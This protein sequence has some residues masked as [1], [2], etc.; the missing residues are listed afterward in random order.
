MIL[1]GFFMMVGG[2]E[3]YG[4]II[5]VLGLLLFFTGLRYIIYYFRTGRFMVGG[6]MILFIGVILFDFGLFTMTLHDEPR[7]IVVIY[8]IA[9]YAFAGLIDLLRAVE[10]KKF[11]AGAWKMKLMIGIVEMSVAA[12]ALYFGLII[13]SPKYVVLVYSLGVMFSGLM[14]IANSFR[15]TAVVYIQ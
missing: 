2:E 1:F 15:R 14:R 8:M 12:I 4:V 5:A 10:A 7:I 6:R 3:F 11:Q 9:F 13:R